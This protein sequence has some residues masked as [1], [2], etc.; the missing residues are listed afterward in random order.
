[1]TKV[2]ST[3]L[4]LTTLLLIFKTMCSYPLN[5]RKDIWDSLH[6][7]LSPTGVLLYGPPGTG[8]TTV[9]R[10]I[11]NELGLRLIMITPSTLLSKWQRESEKLVAALFSLARRLDEIDSI[12]GVRSSEDGSHVNFFKS[13]FLAAW[14]GMTSPTAAAAHDR[15][16]VLGATDRKDSIDKA[17]LRRMPMQR[18]FSETPTSPRASIGKD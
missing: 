6:F 7:L 2:R 4:D 9:A 16:L 15:I 13:E 11:A 12:M 1:M 10:M 3:S 5:I 18:P 14:D 17:F 8:K